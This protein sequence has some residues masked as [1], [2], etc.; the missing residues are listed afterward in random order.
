MGHETV[1]VTGNNNIQTRLSF[2]RV[3]RVV[4]PSSLCHTLPPSTPLFAFI[5]LF[6]NRFDP[7][8]F[9]QTLC[10]CFD[11]AGFSVASNFGAGAST[12]YYNHDGLENLLHRRFNWNLSKFPTMSS[13]LL[14]VW[15]PWSVLR[16]RD[17]L[18]LGV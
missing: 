7:R 6:P 1:E 15:Q 17:E 2:W 18:G 9:F 5:R 4:H 8:C 10:A 13:K 11:L 14:Q 3:H 16:T 12:L